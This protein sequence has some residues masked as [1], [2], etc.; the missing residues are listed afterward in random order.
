MIPTHIFA[1]LRIICLGSPDYGTKRLFF[2]MDNLSLGAVQIYDLDYC[3][4]ILCIQMFSEAAALLKMPQSK[5]KKSKFKCKRVSA[6]V[7][8]ATL[9]FFVN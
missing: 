2:E 5:F 3:S 8:L 1:Y 4:N 9:T 7:T 6:L